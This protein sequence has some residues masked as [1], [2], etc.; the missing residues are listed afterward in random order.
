MVWNLD[1]QHP[2]RRLFAGLVE[3]VFF[4]DLGLCDPRMTDYLSGLLVEFVH[5]DH[6]YRL[7]DVDGQVI[8]EVSRMEAEAHLGEAVEDKTRAS[9]IN[10]YIGDFTLFW[11][12]V[13]PE[14]LRPRLAGVDRLSEFVLQGKRSYGIAGELSHEHADPPPA[15]LRR[16]SEEFEVCVHGLQLVRSGW[17]RLAQ[18]ARRDPRSR[19]SN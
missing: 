14:S 16:L 19:G 11:A 17:E 10:R 2:L 5:V 12:G 15:L 13:Y 9:I 7:R 18:Q 3:Q 4:V 8:R 1:E 6:I